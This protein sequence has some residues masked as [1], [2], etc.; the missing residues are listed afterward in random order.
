MTQKTINNLY[1]S[2][3]DITTSYYDQLSHKDKKDFLHKENFD[4]G[5]LIDTLDLIITIIAGIISSFK[6]LI[7]ILLTIIV[8][9]SGIKFVDITTKRLADRK[10][11]DASSYGGLQSALID[12]TDFF[13]KF[14]TIIMIIISFIVCI[15]LC[16][17]LLN[18]LVNGKLYNEKIFNM[19]YSFLYKIFIKPLE[20]IK[21][22][23]QGN[24]I[25]K[26][27][28]SNEEEVLLNQLNT[29]YYDLDNKKVV[30]LYQIMCDAQYD[31]EYK[32]YTFNILPEYDNYISESLI[33]FSLTEDQKEL[34]E[35]L[36]L[37]IKSFELKKEE[38]IH[39][40]K[41]ELKITKLNDKKQLLDYYN[42]KNEKI[43]SQLKEIYEN[44]DDVE[45]IKARHDLLK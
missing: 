22:K 30:L 40:L 43:S 6:E 38:V 18:K 4:K 19:I 31:S 17:Q 3:N 24:S 28:T 42:D 9:I 7:Y 34:I 25:L 20:V 29:R 13:A 1:L 16:M 10:E 39:K 27:I 36:E 32:Q 33:N 35:L 8:T 26:N 21:L 41:N 11:N 45:F 15:I 5:A 2:D 37:Y 14:M 44:A 23:I 12:S